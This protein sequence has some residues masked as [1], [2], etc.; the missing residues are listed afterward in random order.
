VANH[1]LPVRTYF[2]VWAALMFLLIL[3]I[4]F[5]LIDLGWGNTVVAFAIAAAK[6]LLVGCFFMHLYYDD[7]L[8]SVFALA[9]VF[10]L[11]IMISLA[12]SDYLTRH[13]LSGPRL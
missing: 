2:L 10:W 11:M 12:L 6:A 5:D 3:T 4:G 7:R 8:T 1:I 9:G 13:V